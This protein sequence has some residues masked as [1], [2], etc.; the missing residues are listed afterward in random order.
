MVR[1]TSVVIC[2]AL[3]ALVG[4]ARASSSVDDL[5][6]EVEKLRRDIA[7]KQESKTAI[8]GKVDELVGS[9]YGPGSAVTTK[10]R[11]ILQFVNRKWKGFRYF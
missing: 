7:Q 9:K 3:F 10:S 4:F 6:K 1:A 11:S 2:V 8:G 5:K